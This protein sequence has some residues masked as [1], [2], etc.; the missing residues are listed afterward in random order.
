LTPS[1][2]CSAPSATPPAT[3]PQPACWRGAVPVTTG[4]R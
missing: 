3:W 1:P 2:T 4:M